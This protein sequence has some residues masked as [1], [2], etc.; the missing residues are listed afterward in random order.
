MVEIFE[1]LEI[2]WNRRKY[3]LPF[4]TNTKSNTE[5]GHVSQKFE[6]E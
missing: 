3:T 5:N 4:N 6:L 2:E 1:F